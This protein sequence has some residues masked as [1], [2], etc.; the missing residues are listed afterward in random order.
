MPSNYPSWASWTSREVYLPASFHTLASFKGALSTLK[1]AFADKSVFEGGKVDAPLLFLG[2]IYRECRRAMEI[3]PGAPT[4]AP[5]HLV[6]S[7]FGVKE[8]EE[9][10]MLMTGVCLPTNQ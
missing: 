5:A 6:E 3:E 7:N 4:K 8:I 2:L 1:K 9:I 10:E